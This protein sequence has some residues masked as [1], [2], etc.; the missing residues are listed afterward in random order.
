MIQSY[1]TA[2]VDIL[3]P[4]VRHREFRDFVRSNVEIFERNQSLWNN[5]LELTFNALE[6]SRI[7]NDWPKIGR[8]DDGFSYYYGMFPDSFEDRF[9]L[10]MLSRSFARGSHNECLTRFAADLISEHERFLRFHGE[11]DDYGIDSRCAV[12]GVF[13]LLTQDS[14]EL[15]PDK[16]LE[17]CQQF[18]DIVFDINFSENLRQKWLNRIDA[19]SQSVVREYILSNGVL[20]SP[21]ADPCPAGEPP[22]ETYP[23]CSL[24]PYQWPG[25]YANDKWIYENIEQHTLADLSVEHKIVA[26]EKGWR[27][28]FSR[29]QYKTRSRR[30]AEFHGLEPRRLSKHFRR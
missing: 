5:Q 7:S 14:S 6:P 29:N 26:D 19:I 18:I 11:P 2:A 1:F 21:E 16:H 17:H 15:L 30:F 13:W 8:I 27:S 12:V 28:G 25:E 3:R 24:T 4:W 23:L 22:T 10:F 20:F 9:P